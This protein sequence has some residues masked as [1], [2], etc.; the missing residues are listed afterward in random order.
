MLPIQVKEMIE[1]GLPNAII[2]INSEDGSHFE[3]IVVSEAFA[4]LSMVKQHQ[5]VYALL[6]EAIKAN[7]IHALSLKTYTPD[8][9]E[10]AKKSQL[11]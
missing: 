3:A 1:E 4:D 10:K 5:K 6:D 7:A 11:A 2:E 9:W 8:S